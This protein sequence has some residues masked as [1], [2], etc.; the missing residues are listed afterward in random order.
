[1]KESHLDMVR[2]VLVSGTSWS[3]NHNPG[4]AKQP[5]PCQ[6]G[7][8]SSSKAVMQRI[9]IRLGE[10]FV[11]ESNRHEVE[12][13]IHTARVWGGP[14]LAR[15]YRDWEAAPVALARKPLCFPRLKMP[16][17]L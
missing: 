3:W 5:P 15:R 4:L 8:L 10:L 12:Q 6:G 7:G 14:G 9:A 16:Q 13:R 1:M 17:R 11:P 2:V